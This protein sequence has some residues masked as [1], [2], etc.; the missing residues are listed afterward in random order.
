MQEFLPMMM[1]CP[2]FE[3]IAAADLPGLLGCLQAKCMLHARG[4]VIL[5]QGDA[6]LQLGI[7]L[8]GT[9]QVVRDSY[10]GSRSILAHLEA[11]DM[12]AEAFACAG[13]VSMPVSVVAS[14]EA[15]V[16]LISAEKLMHPCEK[17]CFFHHQII[18]NLMKIL[19]RKNIMSTQKLE[20]VTRRT[21]REKLL[22]FLAQ[23]AGKAGKKSFNIPYTRQELA[24]YLAV[25]RSGLSAE[26][27]KLC[28]EGVIACSKNRFTLLSPAALHPQEGDV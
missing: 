25:D 19:A 28:R 4:Q 27:G 15:R 7:V 12:F 18:F 17:P 10:D 11:G 1:R 22:T 8:E 5:A 21:T 24:D 9:A 16:L 2:L 14:G 13:A 23:Q 26:I 3:G 6:A 20:V